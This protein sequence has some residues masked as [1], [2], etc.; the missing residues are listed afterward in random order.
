MIIPKSEIAEKLSKLKIAL[1]TNDS[2]TPPS[3]CG[4]LVKG[5]RLVA[6]NLEMS[7]STTFSID[8]IE[9]LN[10]NFILPAKAVDMIASLPNV[11]VEI[12]AT[13][14][15][16][17]IT[18]GKIK[19]KFAA[20]T[21]EDFQ[22]PPEPKDD[23]DSFTIDG[24]RLNDMISSV[25]YAA[26]I[27]GERPINTGVLFEAKDGYL[28]LVAVDGYRLA[29]NRS[30]FEGDFKFVVPRKALSALMKL[31]IT[32]DIEISA[33]KNNAIFRGTDYIF[34]T[35]LLAGNFFDYRAAYPAHS[36]SIEVDT[37]SL[38]D[39]IGR[40][41]LCLDNVGNSPAIVTFDDGILTLSL[42]SA[43]AQYSEDIAIEGEVDKSLR[44]G[45]NPKYLRDALKSCTG[46]KVGIS[47]GTESQP[48]VMESEDLR[49]LVLPVRLNKS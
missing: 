49:P 37:K 44:I 14:S 29:W 36:Y 21:T 34:H 18:A 46:K 24:A 22:E 41:M 20:L 28:N 42:N 7:I 2:Q 11:D 27:G 39:S 6:S 26:A 8:S 35:G 19:N 47:F 13:E 16:V 30:K 12:L 31:G 32:G 9:S 15:Q 4:V 10:P 38:L 3:M 25:L 1:S 48:V 5:N 45:F 40:I 17:G 43:F 23:A 33:S